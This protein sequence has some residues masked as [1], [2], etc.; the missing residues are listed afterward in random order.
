MSTVFGTE[1]KFTWYSS[2]MVAFR[3]RVGSDT[4]EYL[5]L[6]AGY[7]SCHWTLPKYQVD[8]PDED[9]MLQCAFEAMEDKCGLS[10]NVDYWIPERYN[11]DEAN[12]EPVSHDVTYTVRDNG[13]DRP[14]L[15]RYFLCEAFNAPDYYEHKAIEVSEDYT[16]H[17]WMS[18]QEMRNSASLSLQTLAAGVLE[19][20][21]E[22]TTRMINGEI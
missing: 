21:H 13:I 16:E 17:T 20:F 19:N 5:V 14:K 1:M 15:V 2:G 22:R 3:K 9:D 18:L 12:V 7:G 8:D 10:V 11:A 6:K 4:V